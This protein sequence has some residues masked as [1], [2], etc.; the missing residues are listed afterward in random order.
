MSTGKVEFY[1][2]VRKFG[3][4]IPDDDDQYNFMFNGE[5][6]FQHGDIVEFERTLAGEKGPKAVD[7][8]KV[9]PSE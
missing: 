5:Y 9:T 4:I 8:R 1:N 2:K 7:I 6:D 3:F